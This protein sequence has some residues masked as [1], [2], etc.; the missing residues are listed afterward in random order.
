LRDTKTVDITKRYNGDNWSILVETL[1]S[2]TPNGV[3][4]TE[5]EVVVDMINISKP[6]GFVV[7][8]L[9]RATL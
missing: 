5:A 8:H 7:T 9:C 6:L 2:E 4:D 1:T 3:D